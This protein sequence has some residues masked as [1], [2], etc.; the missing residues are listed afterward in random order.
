MYNYIHTYIQ[1]VR[2][3]SNM[4][5]RVVHELTED[6]RGG[7]NTKITKNLRTII[8]LTFVKIVTKILNV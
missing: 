7:I 4:H 1:E 2:Y 6:E 3:T 8:I 5:I